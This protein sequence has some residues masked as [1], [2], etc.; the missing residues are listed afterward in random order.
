MKDWTST[1]A[2]FKQRRQPAETPGHSSSRRQGMNR[3]TNRN[4]ARDRL[5]QLVK[6]LSRRPRR[7]LQAVPRRPRP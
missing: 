3:P 6:R 2:D 7:R 1:I 4:E 5:D